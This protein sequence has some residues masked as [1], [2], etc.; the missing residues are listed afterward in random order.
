MYE[1]IKLVHI[2]QTPFRHSFFSPV[3]FSSDRKYKVSISNEPHEP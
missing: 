3:N 2:L 1:F